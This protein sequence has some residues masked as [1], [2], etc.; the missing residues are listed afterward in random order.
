M[1]DESLH[2][3]LVFLG[4]LPERDRERVAATSLE[5]VGTLPAARL[6]PT[7]LV[8]VPRGRPRLFS[9]ELDDEGGR[10]AAIQAAASGALAAASLYEPERRPFWPHLT[11]ARVRGGQRV[12]RLDAA[13][14][15]LA[16][17]ARR[18]TLYRSHLSPRGA[19]YEALD[20]VEL[21][22]EGKGGAAGRLRP[23]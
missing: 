23:A 3:T 16:I 15:E 17:E 4:H 13:V 2:L 1:P 11:I 18:V 6:R 10:A 8:G 21:G 19:R 20:G 9:L 22:G 7:G 14:P 5:A 12:K